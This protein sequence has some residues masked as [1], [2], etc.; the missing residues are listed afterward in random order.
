[1]ADFSKSLSTL[2]NRRAADSTG[3]TYEAIKAIAAAPG[4][5]RVL[6]A[7]VEGICCGAELPPEI[8]PYFS[9]AT[10]I[11]LDKGKG[12][13]RPLAIGRTLRRVCSH[14]LCTAFSQAFGDKL[15]PIQFGVG[16]PGGCFSM[17]TSIRTL[18]G[19]HKDWC[20]C[21]VDCSNAFNTLSRASIRSALTEHFPDLLPYFDLTYG[22]VGKLKVVMKKQ[23]CS[24]QSV[25]YIG[26]VEGCQQGDPLGTFLF[27][28]T[29]QD[30]LEQCQRLGV[31]VFAYVDDVVLIGPHDAVRAAFACLRDA[32]AAKSLSVNHDKCHW[33]SLDPAE[34]IDGIAN[35]DIGL[36]VIKVPFGQDHYARKEALD[37]MLKTV[38]KPL[39]LISRWLRICE[40]ADAQSLLHLARHIITS[41]AA[42]L[43]RCIPPSL[44]MPAAAAAS[45]AARECLAALVRSDALPDSAW[46]Q[47][48]LQ[49][50]PGLGVPDP[51]RAAVQCFAAMIHGFLNST[52]L[53]T[54]VHDSLNAILA[55]QDSSFAKDVQA[56]C[57]TVKTL[58]SARPTIETNK[59]LSIMGRFADRDVENHMTAAVPADRLRLTALSQP[60]A[61][62]WLFSF[63]CDINTRFPRGRVF[64]VALCRYLGMPPCVDVP[65]H[66]ICSATMEPEYD[67]LTVCHCLGAQTTR[68]NHLR[69]CNSLENYFF[70]GVNPPESRSFGALPAFLRAREP[71]RIAARAEPRYN[72]TE[73]ICSH[74]W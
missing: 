41:K 68:H 64:S 72:D 31:E 8:K 62:S 49:R 54:R 9:G 35:N 2:P 30:A 34:K 10:L 70:R 1:M 24:P 58:N 13:P 67:H 18:L 47:A 38:I 60:L 74:I 46:H 17:A 20:A 45:D 7:I 59:K 28:L 42:Y 73:S 37:R 57:E 56:A 33:L 5:E 55:A 16:V 21:T 29:L 3:W 53:S 14:A 69:L 12:D 52:K 50:G 27:C 4:G 65:A 15:A 44:S 26:S 71:R 40:T 61:C 6:H 11:A 39:N 23:G 48:T 22:E 36:L 19:A 25:R 63:G 66:C 32:F 43:F 51:T